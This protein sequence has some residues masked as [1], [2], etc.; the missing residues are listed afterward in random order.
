[1]DK[2]STAMNFQIIT[3][4]CYTFSLQLGL[5][6]GRGYAVRVSTRVEV[7]VGCDTGARENQIFIWKFVSDISNV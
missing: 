7:K 6:K 2:I 1:M 3:V 5:T 4:H